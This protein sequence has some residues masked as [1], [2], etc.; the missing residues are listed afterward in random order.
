[1]GHRR[2]SPC[3]QGADH[4]FEETSLVWVE[5]SLEAIHVDWSHSWA[6]NGVCVSICI[7]VVT[8]FLL[9]QINQET[10]RG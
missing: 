9:L 4:L 6:I 8:V 7:G 2:H 10:G 5:H 3:P 1:M